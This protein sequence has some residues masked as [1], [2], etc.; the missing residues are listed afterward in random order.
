MQQLSAL[1]STF[2]SLETNAAPQHIATLSIYDPSTA[3]GQFVRFKDLLRNFEANIDSSK[4]FTRKLA[5]LPLDVDYPFWIEDPDFDLEFHVRHIALPKPGDWRQLCILIARLHS[6]PLDRNRPLWEAYIIEGLDHV[7]GVPEGAFGMYLKFHHAVADGMG[8]LGL[9]AALHEL[10]PVISEFPEEK[11][12]SERVSLF[13]DGEDVGRTIRTPSMVSLLTKSFQNSLRRPGKAINH[14]RSVVP[15]LLNFDSI[16]DFGVEDGPRGRTPFDAPLSPNRV[17]GG[18]SRPFSEI[19]TIRGLCEGATVN[20]V[21]CAVVSIAVRNYLL[22]RGDLPE[23][24]VKACVPVSMRDQENAVDAGGNDIETIAVSFPTDV[25]NPAEVLREITRTT[26]AHKAFREAHPAGALVDFSRQM[27]AL[28][29]GLASRA[30]SLTVRM[31]GSSPLGA[32]LT[33]SNVPGP[34]APLY[35]AG[36]KCVQGYGVGILTEGAG[37]FNTVSSYQGSLAITFL[38]C[39]KQMPDPEHYQK[40]LGEAFD[41]LLKKSKETPVG[42][43]KPLAKASVEKKTKAKAKPKAKSKAASKAETKARP[44]AKAEPKVKAE[45]KT[46]PKL[47]AGTASE[48][49]AAESTKN[50]AGALGSVVK[51]PVVKESLVKEPS[52]QDS[53]A[54]DNA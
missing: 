17:F 46:E 10:S 50:N 12:P 15:D 30:I 40:C 43:K 29:Q 53:V 33:V 7:E 36:A 18:I 45:P 34:P 54:Q 47:N 16:K 26:A 28:M 1:D 51:E 13:E 5:H 9:Y 19:K 42:K 38:S 39:R 44:K 8:G 22:S 11:K 23:T 49:N 32:S 2:L 27:P 25:S 37:L 31:G 14:I 6:R 21:A 24:R 48:V 41:A 52:V 35:M 20:D 3:P 4:A